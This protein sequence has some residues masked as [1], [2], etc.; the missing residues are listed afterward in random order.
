MDILFA[1]LRKKGDGATLDFLD[2]ITFFYSKCL[3][4]KSWRMGGIEEGWPVYSATPTV[5][6]SSLDFSY[7][8]NKNSD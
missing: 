2:L 5:S 4:D 7:D 8:K 3:S 6:S 1:T